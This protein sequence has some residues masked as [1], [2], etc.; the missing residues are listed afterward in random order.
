MAHF[1]QLDQNNIVIGVYPIA[2]SNCLDSN[3][4]ESEEV[5][6][7]YCQHFFEVLYG[8]NTKWKQTSYNRKIRK[9]YAGIGYSYN[10]ELDVFI[11]P[12][13]YPSWILN[14]EICDWEPPILQPELTEEQRKSGNYYDW[15]EE[16][17]EWKLKTIT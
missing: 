17:Q 11:P 4:N 6:I 1:A 10:E 2:D 5:G 16:T 3:G 13:P 15:N 12:K 7:N 8:P 14:V 9:N